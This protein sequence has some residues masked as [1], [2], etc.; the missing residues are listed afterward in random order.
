MQ[1]KGEEEEVSVKYGILKNRDEKDNYTFEHLCST[2]K[3]ASGSPIL[4]IKNNKII[5]IHKEAYKNNY[6]RGTFLNYPIQEYINK[7]NKDLIEEFNKK[8]NIIIN[9]EKIILCIGEFE[10]E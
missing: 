8:Y 2:K 1:Y 6:N 4:N 10:F 7:Y 5:G 9:K 3:G